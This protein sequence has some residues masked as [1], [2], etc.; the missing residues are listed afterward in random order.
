MYVYHADL[1]PAKNRSDLDWPF[2]ATEG[3][4]YNGMIRLLIYGYLLMF[5][6]NIGPN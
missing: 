4:I 3:Q 2:K 6:S 5:N 1:L